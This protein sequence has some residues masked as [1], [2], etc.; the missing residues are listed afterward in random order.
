MKNKNSV[1]FLQEALKKDVL[2][3]NPPVGSRY[4]FIGHINQFCKKHS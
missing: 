1:D 2:G 3:M 4:N